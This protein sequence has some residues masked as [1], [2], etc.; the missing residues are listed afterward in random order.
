MRQT[1]LFFFFLKYTFKSLLKTHVSSELRT[2]SMIEIQDYS[3]LTQ[4]W[5]DE[6]DGC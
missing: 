5:N 2:V 6:K 1:R 3:N 4:G